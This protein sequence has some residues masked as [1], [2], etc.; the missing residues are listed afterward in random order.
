MG[1]FDPIQFR[2]VRLSLFATSV[3]LI[4]GDA[5]IIYT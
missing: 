3:V 4:K 1:K 5:D 2:L